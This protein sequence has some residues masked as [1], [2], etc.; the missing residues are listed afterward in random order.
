MILTVYNKEKLLY[1]FQILE[2]ERIKDG[3]CHFFS[4]NGVMLKIN[5]ETH[6]FDYEFTEYFHNI[7]PPIQRYDWGGVAK[8]KANGNCEKLEGEQWTAA[9]LKEYGTHIIFSYQKKVE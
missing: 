2:F 1:A 7:N 9:Y 3:E 6:V 8:P 4:Q 5:P